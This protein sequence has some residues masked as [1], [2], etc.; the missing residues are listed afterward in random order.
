MT[1]VSRRRFLQAASAA[2]LSIAIPLPFAQA[3]SRPRNS[4]TGN[5]GNAYL[6]ISADNAVVAVLP[7]AEM[8]QG[9]HTGQL[10]ILGE[11][12]GIAPDQIRVEM[13][14][15]PA[16]PYRLFF[17][18]MRSVG[19]Y[20][21]RAW[22]QPLRTAAAQARSVLTAAAAKR[23]EVSAGQLAA[24]DGAILHRPSGRRLPFG[25]LVAEAA[26][27]PLPQQPA[28]RPPS[29]RRLTGRPMRRVD[30]PA[31]INGSAVFGID[32]K[33]PDML[34]GAVRMSPVYGAEVESFSR[35]SIAGFPGVVD[36]A[37]VPNGVVVIADSWW[38]AKK[39][40][41]ALAIRFTKTPNDKLDSSAL[42][43]AMRAGFNKAM[44]QVVRNGDSDAGF[45]NAA[46]RVEAVYEVPFL[47]HICMEPIVCTAHERSDGV[48]LWMP[49]QAHD[50]VR[51]A[52][53]RVT[54]FSNA[55]MTLHT[56]YLGGGFGRKTHGEIV[57]Q[58]I[59]ASRAVGR[60]VKVTWAREDD[61]QQ[62][63]Y[64]PIM[65]AKLR[66]ALDRKG[67]I[68]ALHIQLS[69]PQMGRT[70]EHVTIKDNRDFFSVAVL[71]DQPYAQH[72]A[73]DHR[74]LDIPMPIS[75]WRA[76]SS[77]QNGYFLEAFIDE[78]AAAAG[79][80][81]LAFRR[82]NL[83]GQHRHLAVL[84][85]VAQM[86]RWQKPAARGIHRGIA[87]VASYGSVVAQV[88]ELR[89]QNEVPK[90][91]RVY[92]AIDCGRAINPDSVVAQMQGSVVEA[93]A[94][95][96][97]HQVPIADGRA[98]RSNFHDYQPL[99]IDEMPAVEVEIVNTGAP[100]GG[101]GEPGL[102]PLAAALANAVH[103]AT[104]KRIRKLPVLDEGRLAI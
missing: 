31:K 60:P 82:A 66:A 4:Q 24:E 49:T 12:L 65:M 91:E 102:P 95:A 100:L 78:L 25:D 89:L 47:T 1:T 50:I 69:G 48:E 52:V 62:G 42:S 30:T 7:T 5:I 74:H 11:E 53:E 56:T 79:M 84:E 88:V 20:G 96:L 103:S 63:Y 23:L 17:G 99:R 81:P 77:S 86:S 76:V 28:L 16:E 37:R 85:R 8:G 3:Q 90:V 94:A 38:R 6:R 18:Q 14:L 19:S 75:P 93:L 73:L 71:V 35:E 68:A 58:A 72:F 64:R 22:Y 26:R 39:A 101:V 32:V 2:V 98:Q 87:V 33:V 9:T 97:R 61:I 59:L 51:M 21:I 104:G 13:P 40:A 27:L 57:E 70:F 67:K 10:M 15:R 44:P 46:K 92:V 36:I 43:A 41:D 55:Q 54:K 80:D 29:E 34:H 83:S 45:K